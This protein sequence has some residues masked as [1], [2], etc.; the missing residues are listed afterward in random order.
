MRIKYVGSVYGVKR[1]LTNICRIKGLELKGR[2]Q[3]TQIEDV[4]SSVDTAVS[5]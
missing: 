2:S 1:H 4:N 3:L 5:F